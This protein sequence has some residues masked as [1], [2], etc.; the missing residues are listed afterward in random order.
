MEITC[1]IPDS[2]NALDWITA[3]G[4][5]GALVIAAIAIVMTQRS[6]RRERRHQRLVER[7]RAA[8]EL[9]E[10]YQ[11]MRYLE[12]KAI[13]TTLGDD[14]GPE[15]NAA[16]ARF[17]ARLHAS[18]EPLPLNRVSIGERRPED[19]QDPI[20]SILIAEG[21]DPQKIPAG[22]RRRVQRNELVESI[23]DLRHQINAK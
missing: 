16:K 9:L 23:D 22:A 14:G 13:T 4:T 12:P 21:N 7:H 1:Q 17:T 3:I 20:G 19:P 18:E 15:Y 2:T 6:I 5:V 11:A 10:A 8:V